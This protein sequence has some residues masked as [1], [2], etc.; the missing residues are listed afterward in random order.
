[1]SA[2]TDLRRGRPVMVVPTATDSF[3]LRGPLKFRQKVGTARIPLK[4]KRPISTA[5][6]PS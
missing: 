4:C 5:C 3:V 6:T 1:M 2:R